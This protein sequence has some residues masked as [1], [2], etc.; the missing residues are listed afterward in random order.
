MEDLHLL[1]LSMVNRNS[2][3]LSYMRFISSKTFQLR[4]SCFPQCIFQSYSNRQGEIDRAPSAFTGGAL[5]GSRIYL[6][7]YSVSLTIQAL[8]W[9][10]GYCVILE[11]SSREAGQIHI[12]SDFLSFFSSFFSSLSIT[13]QTPL[14]GP[15]LSRQSKLL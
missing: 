11:I 3:Q 15:S 1:K 2:H 8:T 7:V 4:F 12:S 10:M 14:R 6:L 9:S 5:L 13:V